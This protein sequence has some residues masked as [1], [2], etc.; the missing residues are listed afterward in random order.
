MCVK[1]KLKKK[2]KKRRRCCNRF[3]AFSVGQLRVLSACLL[4]CV[5]WLLLQVYMFLS[6][7]PLKNRLAG[8]SCWTW[9]PWL[10][11]AATWWTTAGSGGLTAMWN[12]VAAPWFMSWHTPSQVRISLTC[13]WNQ[14][15]GGRR[16][17]NVCDSRW[18][19]QCHKARAPLPLESR[20]MHDQ[21]LCMA[22]LRVAHYFPKVKFCL[23]T[24][25][26][27]WDETINWGPSCVYA[28]EPVW[29]SGKA[30]GW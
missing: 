21:V 2:K 25:Q 9:S 5:I 30:L 7:F 14:R 17:R 26:S 1:G 29:P 28:C 4:V 22:A 18:E 20:V 3:P 23:Q 19:G 13:I 12:G 10:H 11:S 27:P 8:R 16:S 6:F 24:L 15:L